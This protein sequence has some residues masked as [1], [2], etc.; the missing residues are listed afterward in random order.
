MSFNLIALVKTF[1]RCLTFL[2]VCHNVR[3]FGWEIAHAAVTRRPP[4]SVYAMVPYRG[5]RRG[6]W[7]LSVVQGPFSVNPVPNPNV[8]TRHF[9]IRCR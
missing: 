1:L 8:T 9:F 5:L 7:D 6:F 3:D 2:Y 4:M